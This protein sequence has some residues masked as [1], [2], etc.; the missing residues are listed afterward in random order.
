MNKIFKNS[1]IYTFCAL[2]Q[3]GSGFLLLPVYTSYLTPEDYG[4]MNLITSIT[5]FLSILFLCSLHAA[6]GRFHFKYDSLKEQSVAWGTILLLVLFNSFFWGGISIIFHN[7]LIDPFA[8]GVPFYPLV[9][10]AL[11]GTI[12]SPLYLFYQKW[13]QCKQE[14]GK[15]ARNLVLNF[16]LQTIL[17]LILLIFFH[18]GV[19]GMILSSFIVSLIF[20]IYSLIKFIPNVSLHINKPIAKSAIK[21]SLPLLP[22]SVSGY[23]SVMVDRILLNK[24]VSS[25][26]VGLYSVANQFG[27]ILYVVT[28]SI[29]QAFNPWLF[30]I[31][32][33]RPT[34]SDLLPIY[35][36]AEISTIICCFIALTVTILSPELIMLMTQKNFHISWQPIIYISFGYVLNGLYF[37]YSNSLFL[38]HT[39]YVMI[40]S[41]SAAV[42]NFVLNIILIPYWGYCGA[43]I[44][45]L[46]TQ[47]VSSV[48]SL[49]LSRRLVPILTFNW[50][51]MYFSCFIFFLLSAIVY[52]I[53]LLDSVMLRLT[54]EIS[55]IILVGG[56]TTYLYRTNI[57]IFIN[58]LKKK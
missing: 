5:G 52:I 27:N 2:L 55:L 25:Y 28:S 56:I 31:L 24:M 10:I 49:L 19:T 44:A 53:Q 43:G 40:I 46:I 13:L 29:N 21:Y 23:S 18:K 20:F 35:T 12:L 15:Y 34:K 38:S 33:R 6:A 37:F 47:L 22:H 50:G 54:S 11:I 14:G 26:E 8:T 51:K 9:F 30:E 16:V 36:F 4:I 39:K 41:I 7:V 57:N 32:E 17:N 48:I 1:S 45:F 58:K 3:K 42:I